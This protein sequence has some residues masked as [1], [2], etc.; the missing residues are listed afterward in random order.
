[1]KS[2]ILVAQLFFACLCL[3][4]SAPVSARPGGSSSQAPPPDWLIRLFPDT[5]KPDRL[6]HRLRRIS[7]GELDVKGRAGGM[8]TVELTPELSDFVVY[9]PTTVTLPREQVHRRHEVA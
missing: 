4:V 5:E 7:T 1:M 2:V 9:E 6:A 3:S 8:V